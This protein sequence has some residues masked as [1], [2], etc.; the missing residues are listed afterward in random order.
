MKFLND[1]EIAGRIKQLIGNKSVREIAIGADIDPSQF[2]KI[3]KGDLSISENIIEKLTKVYSWDGNFILYGHRTNVPHETM[4]E[5][6]ETYLEKR[7]NI[8]NH[9]NNNTLMYYD[10][11]AHAGHANAAEILPVKKSEGVLHINDL[12]KGSEFAIR[13][14]GNSMTPNYPSGAIIGI[15]QIQDKMITP[16]SV[17]VIEKDDELWIKRLFYKE[18]KQESGYFECVSDNVMKHAE[19]PRQGKLFYP[20]FYIPIDKVRKLFKVTGIFKSNILTVIN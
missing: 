6:P 1:A 12:F 8:K 14:A 4:V 20:S 13:I 11:K 15:K 5:E 10:V 2:N 7:R 18:D 3:V 17:Y 16:G 9:Q 19:G